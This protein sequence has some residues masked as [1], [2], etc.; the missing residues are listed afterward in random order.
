MNNSRS[1]IKES[2]RRE[3]EFDKVIS[4]LKDFAKSES[5]KERISN[6][7]ILH[8]PKVLN[9]HLDCLEEFQY[10]HSDIKFPRFEYVDLSEAIKY[11][12]IENAVLV[13]DQLFQ[14]YDATNWVNDLIY[15]INHNDIEIPATRLLLGDLKKSLTIKNCIDK[16]FTPKR[17]IRS[18]ASKNLKLI[19]QEI[20]KKRAKVAKFF[21]ESVSHYVHL[22]FLDNIKES[23]ADGAAL[24]AVSSEH[25]RKVK[26]QVRGQSK[27]KS[28]TFIEPDKCIQINREL[29]H[30]YNEEKEELRRILKQLTADIALSIDR[31]I[32]TKR[33][34][35]DIDFLSAKRQLSE[36]M[37]AS[38]PNIS[39]SKEITIK[40]AYHPLLL[41]ENNKRKLQTIPQ[42][43]FFDDKHRVIVISGPNA[44]GK[45]ITLKTFGLNQLMLQ[46][47]L[48]IP[49]H[50]N[51]SLRIFHDIY[52]DIGDNQSIENELSTY[53]YRLNRMKQI[54]S[55]A[56][57]SSFVLIDEFGS[58]SDPVLGGELAAVFFKEIVSSGAY[59]VL[60]T[61]YGNI[62]LL[63]EQTDDAENACMLFDDELLNPLYKLKVGQPGSS[64]TFEVAENVGLPISLIDEA[65]SKLKNGTLRFEDTIHHYQQLSRDL[66]LA[67]NELK[68]QNET[69]K[70]QKED[71]DKKLQSLQQK[72][73]S[74][75]FI[76]EFESKYL[77]LGKRVNKFI[78]LYREGSSMKSIVS[79]F[80]KI[81]E[82]ESNRKEENRKNP[83]KNQ[84]H[85]KRIKANFNLGQ[86]VRIEGTNQQ[87]EILELK[88]NS[89]LLQI[90]FANMEVKL[91]KLEPVNN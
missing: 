84:K 28:I 43:I 71:Y 15:F 86:E 19:R 21:Q 1:N 75:R 17:F 82:K 89:A 12:E 76:M 88:S 38:R 79:R 26:G 35:E 3:L 24:L 59:G 41:I 46:A 7:S 63:A 50:P 55:D 72:I 51:S 65:K 14:I 16:V 34:M 4:L 81:I 20:S 77:Q 68:T 48:F 62:K 54:L 60:T 47:G 5:N 66:E 39:N 61:H 85:K 36:L 53:S 58:G 80:K 52:T 74:Q 18:N 70:A 27:T 67:K 69:V 25:K 10:I 23:Y 73:E 57:K 64:Y 32:A 33:I 45:S 49:V 91:D 56:S 2:V 22:G 11:L 8:N 29:T 78:E 42:D 13:E 44:G 90:G 87:G 40:E 31:V 9:F 30:L 6:L 37:N 83:K